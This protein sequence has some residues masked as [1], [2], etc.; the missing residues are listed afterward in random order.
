MV[1]VSG[2]ALGSAERDDLVT[3]NVAK[4]VQIPTPRYKVGKAL[5][6]VDVKRLLAE[7]KKTRLYALYVGRQG[8]A[9][10]DVT[11][12]IYAHTNLDAMREALDAI[13]WEI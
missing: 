12:S 4:L 7:A 13:D 11:L 6:V 10:L 1:T 5:R 9:D 3:R 8:H 2:E